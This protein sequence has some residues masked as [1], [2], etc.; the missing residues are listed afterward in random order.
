MAQAKRQNELIL[1]SVREGI[2]GLDLEGKITLS[3][4]SGEALGWDPAELVGRDAH[5]TFHH[6]RPGG[7]D[8]P[9]AECP[10]HAALAH[11]EMREAADETFLHKT[12]IRFPVEFRTAPLMEEGKLVGA[13][14]VFRQGHYQ[15]AERA[16]EELKAAQN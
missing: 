6:M 5:G 7:C 10:V 11:G 4:P 15:A 3:I 2:C 14:I 13:V 9:R 16:E 1:D 12:G 8:Y